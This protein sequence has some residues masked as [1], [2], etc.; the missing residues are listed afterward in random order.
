MA[1]LSPKA[2][3]LFYNPSHFKL[4][5]SNVPKISILPSKPLFR[6]LHCSSSSEKADNLFSANSFS[7]KNLKKKFK[8]TLENTV[9]DTKKAFETLEDEV[10]GSKSAFKE[11]MKDAVDE[12]LEI[13]KEVENT[14]FGE[15]GE[16][17]SDD[18]PV[19]IKNTVDDTKKV[20]ETFE[21]KVDGSN[22]AL[23][24]TLKDTVDENL[25]TAKEVETINFG[26]S[27]E[28]K[29]DDEFAVTTLPGSLPEIS[30]G[31]GGVVTTLPGI[32]PEI[33]LG[34]GGAKSPRT[35]IGYVEVSADKSRFDEIEGLKRCLVDSFYGT[36]LGLRATSE[37]R[38]EIVELVNQLEALNPTS[39]P[40]ESL[41]LLDGNWVL[42]YTAFSELLPLIA[43]G[44]L[45]LLELEKI[46]QE[47]NT[48]SFT[49]QNSITYSSP[50]ATFSFSASASF[51]VRSPSRI[52]VK[53]EEGVFNPPEIRTP[54]DLPT[55]VD[56]FGQSIDLSPLS[57]VLSPLEE[58]FANIS[59]AISGQPPLKLRIPG[60]GSES[61]LLI[62]YLDKDLRISRGDGGLFVLVKEGSPLLD[63]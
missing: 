53:F 29:L 1:L 9:D 17:K 24:E 61:W 2:P 57:S 60:Q 52:Q 5:P 20:F 21:D 27:G 50:L 44:T 42:R 54:A 33:S 4:C 32:L 39:A 35:E 45:P 19:V 16:K 62:S 22:S 30:P 63:Q 46:C 34:N 51:E 58:G 36:E 59:R 47:I 37:T 6:H 14:I 8:E 38:A 18:E 12:T 25:E 28:K 26:E 55:K 56:V 41:S 48:K 7:R 11:T 49:V 31:N 43:A 10:D 40:T 23:K 3:L 13:A 15:S